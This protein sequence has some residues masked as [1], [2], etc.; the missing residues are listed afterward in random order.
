M[1]SELTLKQAIKLAYSDATTS[2]NK[3]AKL[4][5]ATSIDRDKTQKGGN[6]KRRY[7]NITFGLINSKDLYLVNIHDGKVNEHAVFPNEGDEF[8]PESY[9]ITDLSEIKYDTPELLRKA[10]KITKLY[11]G[12]IFA[13]GYNFRITKGPGKN[14]ILVKIIGWDKERKNMKYLMF[15]G[16]TGELHH[17]FEREQYKQ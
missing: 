15:D 13:K 12:D 7:W 3:H 11:P 8:R 6:G 2:W 16:K 4:I 14:I 17:H 9:F 1:Q 10:K 5:D